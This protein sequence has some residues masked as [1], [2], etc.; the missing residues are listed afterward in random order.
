M[1]DLIDELATI[2]A[3]N[4]I[5]R[6]CLAMDHEEKLLTWQQV[7]DSTLAILLVYRDEMRA[8]REAMAHACPN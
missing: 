5:N 6:Y 4:Y 2:G 8:Q 7:Y 1:T 3:N